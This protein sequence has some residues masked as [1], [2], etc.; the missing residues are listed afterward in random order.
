L[1]S[2]A[3]SSGVVPLAATFFSLTLIKAVGISQVILHWPKVWWPSA[4]MGQGHC[5]NFLGLNIRSSSLGT[6]LL[7]LSSCILDF[8]HPVTYPWSLPWP[9]CGTLPCYLSCLSNRVL[10]LGSGSGSSAHGSVFILGQTTSSLALLFTPMKGVF[11]GCCQFGKESGREELVLLHHLNGSKILAYCQ[12]KSCI[13]PGSANQS[14]LAD[15]HN[16]AKSSGCVQKAT[17]GIVPSSSSSEHQIGVIDCRYQSCVYSHIPQRLEATC[18][19]FLK[20][21]NSSF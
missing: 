1:T 20:C 16:S 9:W 3:S 18:R 2:I 6:P 21:A 11:V 10:L 14:Y 15:I 4:C 5:C 8:V 17:L 19:Q 13:L 12:G 7:L